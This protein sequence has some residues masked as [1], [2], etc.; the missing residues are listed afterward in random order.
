MSDVPLIVRAL[1][2]WC[3]LV[4]VLLKVAV[5]VDRK[6]IAA[7]FSDGAASFGCGMLLNAGR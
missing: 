4:E 3:L 6:S 5:P 7:T 1:S 2:D